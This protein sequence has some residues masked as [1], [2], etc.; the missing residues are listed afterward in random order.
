MMDSTILYGKPVGFLVICCHTSL[1]AEKKVWKMAKSNYTDA[2]LML[3]PWVFS[4]LITTK[5]RKKRKICYPQ[6]YFTRRRGVQTCWYSAALLH[7]LIAGSLIRQVCSFLPM[8]ASFGEKGPGAVL[9]ITKGER[10]AMIWVCGDDIICTWMAGTSTSPCKRIKRETV[11]PL[12][13]SQIT[14]VADSLLIDII[15]LNVSK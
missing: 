8:Y 1:S 7:V 13:F 12:F 14:W 3:L 6:L 2:S 15:I 9:L 5:G 4:L 10:Q 11:A